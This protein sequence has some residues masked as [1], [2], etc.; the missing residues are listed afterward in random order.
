VLHADRGPVCIDNET[1]RIGPFDLD[2]ARTFYR[3]PLSQDDR[4]AFLAGYGAGGGPAGITHL[5]FWSLAAEIYSAFVRCR[6][7]DHDADV[8]LAAL[9][10]RARDSGTMM[11]VH[12][13]A[14]QTKPC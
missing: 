10:Q 7:G 14:E 5:P 6:D 2:L 8:P 3:W 1:L 11:A 13:R 9:R 4:A 12:D